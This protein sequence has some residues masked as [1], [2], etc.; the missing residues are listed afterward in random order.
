MKKDL[1]NAMAKN[2]QKMVNEQPAEDTSKKEEENR[3]DV[4]T[5]IVEIEENPVSSPSI[6]NIIEETNEEQHTEEL[7]HSTQQPSVAQVAPS[8]VIGTTN[9]P[10]NNIPDMQN[11]TQPIQTQSGVNYINSPLPDHIPMPMIQTQVPPQLQTPNIPIQQVAQTPIYMTDQMASPV[12]Q[13]SYNNTML[14]QAEN[15][16]NEVRRTPKAGNKKSIPLMPEEKSSGVLH[17][18]LGELRSYVDFMTQSTKMSYQQYISNLIE[19][20]FEKNKDLYLKYKSFME[21]LNI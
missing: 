12:M 14:N 19:Q 5:K 11:F 6:T 20:D 13:S 1:K 8:P 9:S 17:I 10:V 15:T 18:R 21:Q 2:F 4:E 16:T 7:I 3:E